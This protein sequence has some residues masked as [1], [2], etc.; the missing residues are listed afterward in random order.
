MTRSHRKLKVALGIACLL[1][2]WGGA[3]VVAGEAAEEATAADAVPAAPAP[4]PP[5]KRFIIERTFPAGALDG[6]DAEA[7]AAVNA[8][9]SEHDVRWVY[10]F[11]NA[12]KTK[13]YCVY[14]GPSEEAVRAAADAN[15]LPVDAV[16]E[17]PV[18]LTPN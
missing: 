11:A 1:V 16:T 2:A 13:T 7:K 8:K 4:E 14:D 12:D 5:M 3:A 6:L 10:S 17:I 18:V 15:E 9:N